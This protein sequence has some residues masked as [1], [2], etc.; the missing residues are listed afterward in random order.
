MATWIGEEDEVL[1]ANKVKSFFVDN[2]PESF[3]KIINKE[4]H[5]SILLSISNHIGSYIHSIGR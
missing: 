3:V 2:N 1:D 4:K 5:L